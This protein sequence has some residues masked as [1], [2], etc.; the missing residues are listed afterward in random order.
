MITHVLAL[1]LLSATPTR[2]AVVIGNNQPLSPELGVLRYADDDA[3]R[4]SELLSSNGVE[5]ELLSALDA[6]TQRLYPDLVQQSRPPTMEVLRSTLNRLFE[7]MGPDSELYFFFAG[8]GQVLDNGQ[9]VIHL[10]DQPLSRADLY[11]EVVARS[12][13]RVNHLIIDACNAYFM[14]AS[15][16]EAAEADY[17]SLVRSF[18]AQESLERYPNTGVIVSTV[19]DVEVHEWSK[20]QAGVFSHQLRS[21]LSGAA[22]ADLDGAVDYREVEAFLAAANGQIADPRA[23]I[24]VFSRPPEMYQRAPLLGASPGLPTI[25]V[26][27]SWTGRFSIEDDRG[28]RFADF[29]KTDEVPVRLRVVPRPHYYVRRGNEEI[30]VEPGEERDLSEEAFEPI[31]LAARGSVEDSYGSRLF[32]VPFGPSFVAGF[33]KALEGRPMG[34]EETFNPAVQESQATYA[35]IAW[36][37]AGVTAGLALTFELLSR[38]AA[39]EFERAAGPPESILRYEDRANLYRGLALAAGGVALTS[40]LTA[41]VLTWLDFD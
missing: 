4:I 33:E 20:I 23:R 32:A 2:F 26:P 27:R 5:V 37:S 36:V 24:S 11:R 13:S 17:R 12:P 21:A 29:N 35:R 30:R 34:I 8:H 6:D 1:A 10:L 31:V 7:R 3:A 25:E 15:R 38:D 22:D 19:G 39:R 9:G 14:V 41:G 18:V 16:G 40:A 28:I